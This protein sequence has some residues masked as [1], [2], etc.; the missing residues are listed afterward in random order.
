[1][2]VVIACIGGWLASLLVGQLSFLP[3]GVVTVIQ[4]PVTTGA[5]IALSIETVRYFY[6]HC[7]KKRN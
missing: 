1:M 4:F 7:L 6:N 3:A 5:F 2:I